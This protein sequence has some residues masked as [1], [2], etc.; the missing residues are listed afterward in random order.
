MGSNGQV[1]KRCLSS[2]SDGEDATSYASDT[3]MEKGLADGKAAHSKEPMERKKRGTLPKESVTL[4]TQWLYAHRYNAY[5]SESEKIELSKQAK[6][7]LLQVCNWFINARRRI[8]P[9]MIRSEGQ[10]PQQFT[11]SRRTTNRRRHQIRMQQSSSLESPGKV[12]N[13]YSSSD[14]N[15]NSST[16]SIDDHYQYRNKK[17]RLLQAYAACSKPT[18]MENSD[19]SSN[20]GLT[21]TSDI[22]I[23]VNGHTKTPLPSTSS[24][25]SASSSS[26]TSSK[27]VPVMPRANETKGENGFTGTVSSN[28]KEKLNSS[29]NASTTTVN[30]AVNIIKPEKHRFISSSKPAVTLNNT[31]SHFNQDSALSRTFQNINGK[32]SPA[33]Q[34]AMNYPFNLLVEAAVQMREFELRTQQ[35]A[36]Q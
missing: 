20:S 3:E 17:R 25:S 10:D 6:L 30:M 14:S 9:E 13:G 26:S 4:L 27:N 19:A 29:G 8:L 21:N 24:E 7:S 1:R 16:S 12:N 22:S 2:S 5:P 23:I 28:K 35:T 18:Q 11:I 33:H 34:F 31:S 32:S 15:S 36:P